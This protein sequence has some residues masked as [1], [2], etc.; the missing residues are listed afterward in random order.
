MKRFLSILTILFFTIGSA[1]ADNVSFTAEAPA[2][3]YLNTPFQLV[4]SVNAD[5]KNLIT[6]D[7]QYFEILAGPFTSNSSS[8][9]SINGRM[10]SSVETSYTYTLMPNKEGTFKI[11]AATVTVDGQK[12]FCNN[13]TIKVLPES[14]K[15][16]DQQQQLGGNNERGTSG[17]TSVSDNNV[18]IRASFSKT[19]VYEQEA[20]LV[21]YK[22]YTIPDILQF[23]EMKF[24]DFQ[25]FLTQVID[26]PQNKKLTA[27]TYN[28]KT[29]GTVVLY[30]A[31]LFPQQ[32]GEIKI[33]KADFSAVFR[34]QNRSQV[35]SIFDDFFDSY[36]DV[37]KK[38]VANG[39]TINVR[40]LPLEGKPASFSGSVGRFNLNSTITSTNVKANEP[41]TI[42]VVISGTG[43][44]KLLKNPEIKFPE[45]FDVY[46]PKVDN[47]FGTN[48]SGVTGTKTIEYLFIPR[49]SG[50]YDI[51]SAQLSYFDLQDKTYK[52]LQTPNYRLNVEKGAGGENSVVSNYTN[53]E[54]IQQIGKDIRYIYTDNIKLKE[55]ETPFFGS[56]LFWMLYIIPLL[57]AAI[58]LI[59]FRKLVKENANV[60]F[61]KN[62]RANKVAQKRLK[63]AQKLLSEGKKAQFY[64]EVMK[65]VWTY[66][67]DKLS[68]PVSL[69]NKENITANMSQKNVPNEITNHFMDILNSCE[70]ASYAPN[71]GQQ[72]MGN[73]YDDTAKA[74]GSLEDFLRK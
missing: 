34:V 13:L 55:E 3:V 64:E 53:K 9:Q 20:I 38:L 58:L 27:E 19:N 63:T 69:L 31:L 29:Y 17:S 43:N 57:I 67:S 46:D 60:Q 11:P 47:K 41:V 23:T 44:L 68:I 51:P 59:Y 1:L 33:G 7:F 42:K 32:T 54:D 26:L 6:P 71:S 10:T 73:M 45:S 52:T 66:L 18:F 37:N 4:Y 12:R 50:V 65:T 16:K 30:Q 24:P 61:V 8:Y 14:K 62:K 74:I 56:F 35:R 39:A 28:G 22:L 15:P 21:T 40:S 72:E 36:T 70:F 49:H 2:T 48:S 5:A 25:G